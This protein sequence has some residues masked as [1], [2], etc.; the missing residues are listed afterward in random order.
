MIDFIV[1]NMLRRCLSNPNAISV[2]TFFLTK[3]PYKIVIV[4]FSL[5]RGYIHFLKLEVKKAVKCTLY[6]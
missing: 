5:G 6:F 2:A 3:Y 1:I 4:F